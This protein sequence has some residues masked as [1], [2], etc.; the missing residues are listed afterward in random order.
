M[1][2]SDYSATRLLVNT[3]EGGF[4]PIAVTS[5]L[6]ILLINLVNLLILGLIILA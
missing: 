5:R 1:D 2:S 6:N 4:R 3:D